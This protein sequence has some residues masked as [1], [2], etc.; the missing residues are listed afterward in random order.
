M[1][2]ISD[3]TK[4]ALIDAARDLIKHIDA[5][6]WQKTVIKIT[7]QLLEAKKTGHF[8]AI[9]WI[10]VEYWREIW[11]IYEAFGASEELKKIFRYIIHEIHSTNGVIYDYR[12]I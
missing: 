12:R 8:K 4:L 5:T 7:K 9:G 3:L 11:R 2:Q 10:P 1:E 6:P